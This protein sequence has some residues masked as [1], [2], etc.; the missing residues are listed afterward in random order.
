[1]TKV[2]MIKMMSPKIFYANPDCDKFNVC[3][4]LLSFL[5]INSF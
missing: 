2:V 4:V 3:F 5:P 1:M